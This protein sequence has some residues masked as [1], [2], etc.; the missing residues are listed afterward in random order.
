MGEPFAS[1]TP[2]S[3]SSSRK[4]ELWKGPPPPPDAQQVAK[5]L[6]C[7]GVIGFTLQEALDE[8]Y[9]EQNSNQEQ[10]QPLELDEAEESNQNESELAENPLVRLTLDQSMANRILQSFGEAVAHSQRDRY[11]LATSTAEQEHEHQ[12]KHQPPAAL[13]KGRLVHYNRRNTKWRVVLRDADF[14]RRSPLD[15]NRRK[16][17]RPS[18]WHASREQQLDDFVNGNANGNGNDDIHTGMATATATS[19]STATPTRTNCTIE[20]LAYNDLE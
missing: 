10:L 18:L 14:Q 12:H 8:V 7:Q 16:R 13:L 20:I 2:H 1:S 15:K 11:S 6:S 17:E 9:A 19:T 3:S 4:E 5:D